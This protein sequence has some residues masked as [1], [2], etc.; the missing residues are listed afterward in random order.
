MITVSFGRG[1]APTV[2]MRQKVERLQAELAA[3]PQ[4]EPKT[5]HY[6]HGGMYCREVWREASVM[7]VGKVHKQEHFYLIV[8]GT[9]H[10]TDGDGEPQRFTGPHLI[11]SQPGSKR[12]VYAETDV[13][14]MT[15]HRTD[16]TTVEAAEAELV[17]QDDG[18]MYAPGNV[19]KQEI[20]S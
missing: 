17:E 1:F 2:P 4:Y 15:F 13:L 19:L 7:V 8:S 16:A 18:A 5:T 14:C 3:L 11:A 6:F 9:V 10:I 20:L 12:A